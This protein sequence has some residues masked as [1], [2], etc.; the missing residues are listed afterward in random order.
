MTIA[1]IIARGE[2]FTAW[3]DVELMSG[4]E[5]VGMG[6]SKIALG[7]ASGVIGVGC[8]S[9]HLVRHMHRVVADCG[10]FD[11]ALGMISLE[12]QKEG[13]KVA[14]A[15][16]QLGMP[17]H[18]SIYALGGHS[19]Q[20]RT[21]L[22]AVFQQGNDFRPVFSRSWAMPMPA[23]GWEEDDP[24]VTAH[25]QMAQLRREFPGALG[26]DLVVVSAGPDTVRAEVKRVF[27]FPAVPATVGDASAEGVT[28]EARGG[29]LGALH[30]PSGGRPVSLEVG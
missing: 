8:G 22:V 23:P 7:L 5:S 24:C 3:A 9:W 21:S 28:A 6:A 11:N 26:G 4:G 20:F 12:M 15:A 1:A 13:R 17:E 14:K 10:E 27:F 18:V 30:V 29:S 25:M 2:Q 16:Q 19:R